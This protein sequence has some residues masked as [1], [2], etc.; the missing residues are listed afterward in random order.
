MPNR[1]INADN[2]RINELEQISRIL[3]KRMCLLKQLCKS[4]TMN[5]IKHLIQRKTMKIIA[6]AWQIV[7]QKQT[8][9]LDQRE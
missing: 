2:K 3:I 7:K 1:F 6:N 4:K 8:I 5:L 9:N